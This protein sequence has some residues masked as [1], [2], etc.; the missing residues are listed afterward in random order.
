MR[1][2]PKRNALPVDL[3]RHVMP[4][5]FLC[6]LTRQPYEEPVLAA[7]GYTYEKKALEAWQLQQGDALSPK[8]LQ[9]MKRRPAVPNAVLARTMREYREQGAADVLP[10]RRDDWKDNL[11]CPVSWAVMRR[12]VR[13]GSGANYDVDIAVALLRRYERC[14]VT[15][16]P[17]TRQERLGGLCGPHTL[18]PDR[19][20]QGLAYEWYKDDERLLE[21][22]SRT[23]RKI[24]IEAPSDNY[25]STLRVFNLEPS[26][27][28]LY[29]CV[30][31]NRFGQDKISTKLNV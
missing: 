18:L 10:E 11:T 14:S 30:A 1:H 31:K 17:F 2:I 4:H 6:P 29:S 16:I 19:A 9:T 13:L 22:N 8:T 28:G 5:A 3:G 25:M 27:A 21:G 20:M 26:D 24:R 7:D 23:A 12:P 15:N